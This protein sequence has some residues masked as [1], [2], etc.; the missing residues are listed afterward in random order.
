MRGR[1][2][3][4]AAR[5][6]PARRDREVAGGISLEYLK[7]LYAGYEDFIRDISRTVP[8]IRVDYDRFATA[9]EMARVIQREYLD[10]S[11]LREAVRPDP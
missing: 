4:R 5:L 10:H 3:V 11:F 1:V 7:A 6:C 8:V 2:K 9:E